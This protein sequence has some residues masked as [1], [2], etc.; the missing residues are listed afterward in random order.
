[1]STKVQAYTAS[2][3]ARELNVTVAMIYRWLRQGVLVEDETIAA[4]KLKLVAA[5][6]VALLKAAREGF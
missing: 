2:E 5:K 6:S 4:G 3:A 1:M